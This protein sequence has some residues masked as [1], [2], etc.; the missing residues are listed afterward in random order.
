MDDD[1]MKIDYMQERG[2]TANDLFP[3][4]ADMEQWAATMLV[5]HTGLCRPLIQMRT[6]ASRDQAPTVTYTLLHPMFGSP[7]ARTEENALWYD[8]WMRAHLGDPGLNAEVEA[9]ETP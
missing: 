3:L 2:W 9:G 4:P 1:Q 7:I 5:Q 6:S 8:T